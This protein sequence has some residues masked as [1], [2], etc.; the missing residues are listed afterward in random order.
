MNRRVQTIAGTAT[1]LIFGLTVWAYQP[2]DEKGP[3][4]PAPKGFPR[5]EEDPLSPGLVKKIDPDDD[6][7]DVNVPKGAAYFKL[8]QI[9]RLIP[10]TQDPTLKQFYTTYS[11]AFDRVIEN[12]GKRIRVCPLPKHRDQKYPARFGAFEL[13]DTNVPRPTA[14]AFE[15]SQVSRVQ[16]F[17]E[18]A[19]EVAK[20]LT[21]PTP[22]SGATPIELLSPKIKTELA[23]T[24]LTETLFFTSTAAD[25]G[26]RKGP[27][28]DVLRKHVYD[29]L[30]ITRGKR[31]K[32][33][34]A[35]Q[36]WALA[37]FL[38]V[39]MLD[40][41]ERTPA[42][43]EEVYSAKLSEA[44]TI[45]D[46]AGERPAELERVYLALIDYE[47]KSPNPDKA[48]VAK[49]RSKLAE[50]SKKKLDRAD[51][52]A[53]RDPGTAGRLVTEASRYDP[54]NPKVFELK[55]MLNV[56]YSVLT[57]GY[58]R[59]PERMSP[60]LARYDSEKHA[61][62]LMFEGLV[63][64]VP[65][66]I[67]GTSFRHVLSSRF[68]VVIPNGRAFTLER[69]AI[70]AGGD[71]AAFDA[72]DVRGTVDLLRQRPGTWS[73]LPMEWI[74]DVRADDP[75]HVRMTFSRGH[76][77]PRSLLSFKILPAR[78]LAAQGKAIDD[79][80]FANKPFGSGP[81]VLTESKPN[82]VLF[83]INPTYG[84]RPD[85]PGQPSVKDIQ[86]VSLAGK[87]IVAEF[88]NERIHLLP[89]VPTTELDKF[90]NATTKSGKSALVA[91]ARDDRRV[92]V[93]AVNHR[94]PSLRDPAIRRGLA[95]AIDRENILDEVFR[96]AALAEKP[97]SAMTGPFPPGS[98]VTPRPNFAVGAANQNLQG[99]PPLLNRDLASA[100]FSEYLKNA[101]N[102]NLTLLYPADD[103]QAKKACEK[104]K[105]MVEDLAKIEGNAL[106]L[107]LD[108][109]VPTDYYRRVNE[110]FS[111][112]LAYYAFDYPDDF[113]PFALGAALDPTAAGRN[114]R[115]LFGYLVTDVTYVP[116]DAD[117]TLGKLL[118]EARLYRDP[119]KLSL[120]A[121]DVHTKF[122]EVMPFIPLWRLDRH[123][124]M[125]AAVKPWTDDSSR[126]LPPRFLDP[127]KL[128]L[129][130]S[131]WRVE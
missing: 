101:G 21:K 130:V 60:A 12:S 33:A 25:Q 92:W 37:R 98:W 4:P 17:E 32:Q 90:K 59:L 124:V 91:T 48:R 8:G 9:A 64:P 125:S 100:K 61:V 89:D 121:S 47:A 36:D 24:L 19:I 80:T 56:D 58:R 51:E 109:A 105:K 2:K 27:G 75:S 13:S 68:P 30:A 46:A 97:H 53:A 35:D 31:L 128:F 85:R 72:A 115:N 82:E 118:N 63:D 102:K 77:D 120:L 74:A 50:N 76:I 42:L 127:A 106:T 6:N 93:L 20:D 88:V 5:E 66:E 103:A 40:L 62:E 116:T 110:E 70:W 108:P 81:Y 73:T 87:D 28:W 131:K 107:R 45:L 114:G 52:L 16:H 83:R 113:Y 34:V 43:L 123:I 117:R 1:L 39:R 15:M 11:V 122:N 29:E 104:I 69:S 57:V 18:I 111:Y 112:D 22:T 94:N 14:R 38:G 26:K 41:Y 23:E 3:L 71:R 54:E 119:L 10:L 79:I 49:V 99:P 86:F 129:N 65:D 7:A 67:L 84:R 78:W 126:P 96:S 44:E 55:S 95:H